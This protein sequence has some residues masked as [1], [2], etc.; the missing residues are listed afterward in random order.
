[1]DEANRRARI[2]GYS[3]VKYWFENDIEINDSEMPIPHYR[4]I[5]YIK[6]PILW[7]FYYLK[8]GYTYEQA[9][10]DILLKGGDT[11]ANAAIVGGLLGAAYGESAL[12]KERVTKVL[13]YLDNNE[14]ER[15]SPLRSQIHELIDH[16]PKNL[17][18]IWDKYTLKG[19]QK[20]K[21]HYEECFGQTF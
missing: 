17:N 2:S 15:T 21:S 1:L 8:K 11:Q 12:G 18:V 16:C 20:V 7:S 14:P 4:P 13:N 9:I 19:S 6:V 10:A 5:S 3:T